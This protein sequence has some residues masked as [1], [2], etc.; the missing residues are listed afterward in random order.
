MNKLARYIIIGMGLSIVLFLLWY[1]SH[2]VAYILVAAVLSLVGKPIVD[3][4]CKINIRGWAPPKIIGAAVA[5]VS[6]WLF[7]ILFFRV[8]IPLVISQVN[9]LSTVNVPGM[10]KR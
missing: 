7:F 4:V 1:F 2:I 8:M 9:E 3:L 5:L 6:L 10:L